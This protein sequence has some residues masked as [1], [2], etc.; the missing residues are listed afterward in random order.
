VT[1]TSN[2]PE[3]R[4]RDIGLILRDLLKVIKVVAMYP[5]GNPLP[6]SLRRSFSEKLVSLLDE[7]GDIVLQIN[8]TTLVCDNQT[9]FTDGSKEESLAA[10]FFEVGITELVF[11]QG[12]DVPEMYRFLEIIKQYQNCHDKSVDLAN[13]LWEASLGRISFR[14]LEDIELSEYDGDFRVQEILRAAHGED[15]GGLPMVGDDAEGYEAIFHLDDSSRIELPEE[16]RTVVRRSGEPSMQRRPA[17][18]PFHAVVPGEVPN[19]VFDDGA[20]DEVSF[21]TAEAAEAMGF[22]GLPPGKA[23]VPDT[24]LILNDEFKL[25][26]EQEREIGGRLIEDAQFDM[27]E[28]TVELLKE[29]LHQE[30]E[31]EAF[32]ETVTICERIFNEFIRTAHLAEGGRLLDYFQALE[33][34]LREKR[35]LWAERLRDARHAAGSRERLKFLAEALNGNPEISTADMRRFLDHFGWEALGGITDLLG[36]LDHQIHRQALCDFLAVRGKDNLATVSKGIHD[37]RWYVVRN[38]ITVLAQIGDRQALTYLRKAVTHED[39]RVRQELVKALQEAA[40]AEALDILMHLVR[41]RDAEVRKQAVEAIVA[42]RGQAAFDVI[43]NIMNDDSF[44]SLDRT[45]QEH[46]LTAYSVLG[47]E[48]A[49][50]YLRKLIVRYN[51]FRD[52]VVAFFRKAAF[53]ALAQNKSERCGRLLARLS[54]SWRPDVKRQATAALRQRREQL[55]GGPGEHA[56]T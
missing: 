49:I 43:T 38:S 54:S 14:T 20:I 36:E 40:H 32:F 5:E 50:E 45:E 27:Y 29:M 6:Q 34:Q 13:L 33:D 2:N 12:L 51:P 21:R 42:R 1:D 56:R 15:S 11:K 24:A 7:H 10:L 19:S 16:D 47:G 25:S 23:V 55:Y 26:E 31:M 46:L 17:G 39:A 37:K 28:S 53:H 3:R 30:A 18:T 35:P 48:H 52:P 44:L 41:D 4:L 8:R 22:D 9:V